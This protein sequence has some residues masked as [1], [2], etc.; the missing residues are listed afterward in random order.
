[1]NG[2]YVTTTKTLQFD[3]LLHNGT[4]TFA[5]HLWKVSR[6]LCLKHLKELFGRSHLFEWGYVW[7]FFFCHVI[8]MLLLFFRDKILCNLWAGC[9]IHGTT[10]KGD[11]RALYWLCVEEPLLWNGNAN[12]VRAVWSQSLPGCAKRPGCTFGPLNFMFYSLLCFYI[13][14]FL[15]IRC[16]CLCRNEIWF[17]E[18]F[19]F[20]PLFCDH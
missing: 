19:F 1:M 8:F 14:F 4:F 12:S 17:A 20:F 18:I 7:Y 11:I 9:T 6:E 2:S 3:S 16:M 15:K 10:T 13:V 5:W